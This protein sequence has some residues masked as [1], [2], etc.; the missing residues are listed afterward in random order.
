MLN[1]YF[2]Y[3]HFSFWTSNWF[4]TI[5]AFLCMHYYYIYCIT[6]M[7]LAKW[8]S[9]MYIYSYIYIFIQSYKYDNLPLPS[10]LYLSPS[11]RISNEPLRQFSPITAQ[12]LSTVVFIPLQAFLE[13]VGL[14][15]KYT[16]INIC[17]YTYKYMYTYI[18][19]YTY[20]CTYIYIYIHSLPRNSRT[21]R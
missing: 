18:Y 13:M 7:M 12:G 6:S 3:R 19:T 2:W 11:P 14:P 8:S 17:I 10:N 4:V 21:A 15:G 16:Y 9:H 5:S 1:R 20:K